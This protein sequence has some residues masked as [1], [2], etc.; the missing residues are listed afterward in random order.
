[1]CSQEA[2]MGAEGK[3]EAAGGEE[4]TLAGACP[5]ERSDTGGIYPHCLI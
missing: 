5:G 2:G 1:M 3:R 4:S